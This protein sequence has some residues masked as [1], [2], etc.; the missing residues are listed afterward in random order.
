MIFRRKMASV[1]LC[2]LG[3]FLGSPYFAI[4]NESLEIT[5]LS[6][7]ISDTC[8]WNIACEKLDETRYVCRASGDT[9]SNR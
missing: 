3:L 9:I 5:V 1:L 8:T 6:S 2:I 7:G 4:A